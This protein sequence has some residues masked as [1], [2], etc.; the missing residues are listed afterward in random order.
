VLEINSRGKTAAAIAT[1]THTHIY[2]HTSTHAAHMGA[3]HTTTP[4]HTCMLTPTHR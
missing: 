3:Y 4:P 1:H 2:I